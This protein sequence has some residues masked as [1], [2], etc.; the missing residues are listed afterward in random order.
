MHFDCTFDSKNNSGCDDRALALTIDNSPTKINRELPMS[1]QPI[2][3]PSEP[4]DKKIKLH[5]DVMRGCLRWRMN[6]YA[7]IRSACIKR[8]INPARCSAR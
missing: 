8:S 6:A 4:T 1:S 7:V 3:T 5:P 2:T